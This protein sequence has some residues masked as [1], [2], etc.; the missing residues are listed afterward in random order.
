[1]ASDFNVGD[2]LQINGKPADVTGDF[3]RLND[4]G[5]KFFSVKVKGWRRSTLLVERSDGFEL[6]TLGRGSRYVPATVKFI[7]S[8]SSHE[9]QTDAEDCRVLVPCADPVR[10]QG[11][12]RYHVCERH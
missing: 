10:C 1:M 4:N 12:Q 2:R 3:L 9:C 6:L 5:A 7:A 8:G 11:S